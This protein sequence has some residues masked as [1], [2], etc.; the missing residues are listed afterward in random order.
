MAAQHDFALTALVTSSLNGAWSSE[1]AI[2]LRIQR[3]KFSANPA[4]SS[5]SRLVHHPGVA[6]LLASHKR[7]ALISQA[8]E[9][10]HHL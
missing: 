8:R 10:G 6:S 1:S 5:L 7:A 2:D 9:W 3:I 4:P